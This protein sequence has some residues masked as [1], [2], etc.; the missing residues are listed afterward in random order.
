MLT[1]WDSVS[2]AL[3]L[4]CYRNGLPRDLRQL[5][6]KQMPRI[7]R[8]QS[9]INDRCYVMFGRERPLCRQIRFH[10]LNSITFKCY[11][12]VVE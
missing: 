2:A 7:R 11:P 1:V 4:V 3:W 9:W 6:V 10:A 5:I 8:E 12:D